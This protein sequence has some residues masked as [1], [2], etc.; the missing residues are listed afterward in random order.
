MT[1]EYD[2]QAAYAEAIIEDQIRTEIIDGIKRA[3][4]VRG[5]INNFTENLADGTYRSL[6]KQLDWMDRIM[7]D[8]RYP[9]GSKDTP[10]SELAYTKTWGQFFADVDLAVVESGVDTAELGRLQAL[11][12]QPSLEQRDVQEAQ[13]QCALPAYLQLRIWGYSPFELRR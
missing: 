3:G 11:A 9:A 2:L 13:S 10:H 1:Y 7:T 8:S 5:H 4:S 12:D 6:M